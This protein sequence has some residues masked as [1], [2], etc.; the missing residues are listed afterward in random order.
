MTIQPK[1]HRFSER[2]LTKDNSLTNQRFELLSLVFLAVAGLATAGPVFSFTGITNNS[3]ADTLIGETQLSV[4]VDDAGAGQV[5]FRFY[6]SGA[7]PSSI[8]QIYFDD[9]PAGTGA[10]A[11]FA[12]FDNSDP[13]VLFSAGATP[14]NLP[15]GNS[16]SPT[17]S[18]TAGLTAG[19]NAPPPHNGVNP[20]ESLGILANL[21]A[22]HNY[23][24][25]LDAI[26][27]GALRIGLHV[28]A[29]ESGGSESFITTPRTPPVVPAPGSALLASIGLW[30]FQLLRRRRVAM[31]TV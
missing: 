1:W 27:S 16:I 14:G 18:A 29:F 6:N 31:A 13:G 15:G 3:A 22:A 30:T 17:F 11:S 9:G 7:D 12:A 2:G 26:S 4:G 5:W 28:Q 10:L 8:T 19:A 25:V 21:A 20:G 24:D 23:D